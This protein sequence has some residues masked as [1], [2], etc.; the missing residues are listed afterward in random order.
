MLIPP[1]SSSAA[2]AGAATNIVIVGAG[3]VGNSIAY[4]LS[5]QSQSQS[6]S[7]IITLIDPVGIAPCASGKAG[8]FLAKDWR[9][10]TPLQE[11]QQKGFD[12][13]DQL[14]NELLGPTKNIDYRRLT[15]KSVSIVEQ[16]DQQDQ[17]QQSTKRK[18][19]PPPSN[20]KSNT[21]EWAD[22]GVTGSSS[23]GDETT[24]A[25]VHPKKLC[26]EL[27][28]ISESNG[29]ILKIGK[30]V[31][32]LHDK[33]DDG[34]SSNTSSSSSSSSGSRIIHSVELEDGTSIKADKVV[35]ACGPWSEQ[36]RFWFSSINEND[37]DY[38]L[39]DVLPEI[40]G[41]KCPS[42]MI[43]SPKVVLSEAV[44]FEAEEGTFLGNA[45]LEVYPRPDGDAYVNGFEAHEAVIVTEEPGKEIVE[46]E[47]VSNL[48]DAMRRSTTFMDGTSTTIQAHTKQVCYWPE[49][50]DG[51]PILDQIPG[52]E[53]VA[54]MACG[55]SVWGILQGPI[56]GK[57]MAEL[58][59]TGQSTTIDLSPFKFD[60]PM[61][62][63]SSSSSS[64]SSSD[65]F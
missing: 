33:N 7:H 15:C 26:Q 18:N 54:Y 58:I 49:T 23:M 3:I 46:L 38:S 51:Y 65:S 60:R 31:K 4:F 6:Q 50:P 62:D 56:S 53:G 17:Q 20:R 36:A 32:I 14:A 35:I 2:V 22:K 43:P 64:S 24:I 39:K 59:L 40:T 55:H 9:D 8:G 16:Q 13:H 44:F 30:V 47:A 19:K 41:V 28:N 34:S 63:S 45:A 1:S 52:F 12:L 42:V 57:A 61:M 27:W 5:L 11:L 25:Q 21:L 48:E 10:G 29:C 37:D